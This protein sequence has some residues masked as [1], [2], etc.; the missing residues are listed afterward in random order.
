MSFRP[1]SRIFSA[2]RRTNFAQFYARRN[3]STA[4]EPAGFAK[5]WNSPIGPKTVHFWYAIPTALPDCPC[6]QAHY[7]T[8]ALHAL[9]PDTRPSSRDHHKRPLSEGWYTD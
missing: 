7:C 3:A 8:M 9:T 1:G 5:F 2:F 4:T 6:P